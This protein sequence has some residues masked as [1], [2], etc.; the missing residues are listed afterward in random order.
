MKNIY[1]L[2]SIV[3]VGALLAGCS[4][5]EKQELAEKPE[6]KSKIVTL[7]AASVK[8]IGLERMQV[9]LQPVS[10]TMTIPAKVVANQDNEAVIGSLVQGRVHK[11][12]VNVGDFVK[13]GQVLMTVE[14]LDVGQIKSNFLKS[15][16][17]YEYAKA[18]YER[19]KKLFDEKI[20]SQKS[21]LETQAEYE[22]ASAE[23]KAEDKKIHA[24]GLSDNDILSTKSNDEHTSGT[25]PIKAPISGVV[26][27]R[28]VVLGQL[29]E[30]ATNAFRIINPASIWVDGQ[31]Y[32]KDIAKTLRKSQVEFTS[33][34]FKNEKFTGALTYIGQI[35]DEHSRT[36]T[37]RG[38]FGNPGNKL[39]PNMFGELHIPLAEN[40]KGL[41]VPEE[42]IVNQSGEQFVFVVLNDTS[43]EMRKVKLGGKY[44]QGIEII[45]GIKE[46]DSVVSK[47][48]F[49]LLSEVKK[50]EIE[51]D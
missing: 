3:L 47:G 27:E 9:A 23:F 40:T 35:V 34:S 28:N 51:G 14:G 25:L 48:T 16:A 1:Q 29:I 15:K 22:K 10:G 31:I 12:Y 30:A 39:K 32:E 5:K 2:L 4:K 49:Y 42:S 44:E 20:G 41:I 38:T 24:L 8:D 7:K 13:A 26:V 21:V 6:S 17:A 11:V 18:N 33:A 46:G 43:F 37:V 50:D 45:E 36:I 19:Q